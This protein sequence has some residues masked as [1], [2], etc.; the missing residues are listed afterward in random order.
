MVTESPDYTDAIIPSDTVLL[1]IFGNDVE[2][3]THPV[4]PGRPPRTPLISLSLA[5]KDQPQ[6][7]ILDKEFQYRI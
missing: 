1:D 2:R 5:P 4:P 6:P 7:D 3:P